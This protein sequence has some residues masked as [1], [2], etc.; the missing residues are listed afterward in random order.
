MTPP[1][2][3]ELLNE[4]ISIEARRI[5]HQATH[6]CKGDGA[7][8]PNDY[9]TRNC[10]KLKEEIENLCLQVKCAALQP[11]VA[12]EKQPEYP[13]DFPAPGELGSVPL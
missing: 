1:L 12:S 3:Q 2:R 5:A 6:T 8:E 9:H 7:P 4:Q 10:N 11:K 13:A